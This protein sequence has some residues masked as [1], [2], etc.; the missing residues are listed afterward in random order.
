MLLTDIRP[1]PRIEKPRVCS[2]RG[3]KSTVLTSTPEKDRLI[4]VA[5]EKAEKFAELVEKR[6]VREEKK[7]LKAQELADKEKK[8]ISKKKDQ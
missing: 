5:K 3:G 2:G 1:F 4:A 8:R 6:R 7:A